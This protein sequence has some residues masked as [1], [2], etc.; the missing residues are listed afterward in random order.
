MSSQRGKAWGE[1][2]AGGEVTLC[3]ENEAHPSRSA[4]EES[5]STMSLPITL[6]PSAADDAQLFYD[7]IRPHHALVYREDVGRLGRGPR[8]PRF[9]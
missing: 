7:V 9:K 6:R 1:G 2:G 8:P 5:A 4:G 3:P